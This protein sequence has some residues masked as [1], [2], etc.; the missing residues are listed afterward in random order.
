MNTCEYCLSK[1]WSKNIFAYIF[2]SALGTYKSLPTHKKHTHIFQNRLFTC[3]VNLF[4]LFSLAVGHIK[5]NHKNN[6]C[7]HLI[8]SQKT[9]QTHGAW[10]LPDC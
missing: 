3:I 9:I 4:L 2:K 10:A 7:I 6:L 8:K 5:L 1:R